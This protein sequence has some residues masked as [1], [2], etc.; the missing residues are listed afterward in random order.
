MSGLYADP[1]LYDILYTPGTAAEV[2]A[3]ERI[4]R[5][6]SEGALEPDRL[7]FEPACGTGRYLRVAQRRGRRVAG[8]DLDPGQIAY[9]RRRLGPP[10]RRLFV[11]D[12]LDF[13]AAFDQAGLPRGRIRFAFNP[14]NT[15]R[16][17]TSD[18][19]YL[20]HL[21]QMA[22]VMAPG[23]LY[24][25]GLSLVDYDNL[26]PEEDTWTGRR[27]RCQV[28]QLVNYLPPEPGTA[29]A[30]S[31]TVIS[32]LTVS[33]PRG[34]EHFDSHY[35]LHCCDERQWRQV[36]GKAGVSHLASCDWHGQ[37]QTGRGLSY[38]LEVLRFPARS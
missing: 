12:M 16:H 25:V 20:T 9:A 10:S 26:L 35:S 4:E 29:R 6:Y 28:T 30:R 8:F 15:L 33:R 2:D 37:P 23:G 3:L 22:R 27:G 13:T 17:L 11:A 21:A 32:H 19:A 36:L 24:V 34:E 31:E 14:V 7:W 18:A 1:S 5:R 38:Q